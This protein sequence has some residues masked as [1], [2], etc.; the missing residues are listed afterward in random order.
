MKIL[1]SGGGTGGHIYPALSIADELK[2]IVSEIEIVYVGT[3]AGLERNIVPRYGYEMRYIEVA[4]FRR[5]LSF[6]TIR[7]IYLLYKGLKQAKELI[8][9][10][11]PDLVIGTGGYVCGPVVYQAAKAGIPTCIQEQNALP[12][13]TNRILARMVN[14]VLLG[15]EEA[16]KHFKAKGEVVY[17]GNPIREEILCQNRE[18]SY[19]E[20]RLDPQLKTVLVFGGSRG[21]KSINSAMV[22]VELQLSKRNDVQVLHA[23][24]ETNY[25]DHIKALGSKGGVNGNIHIVPYLHN[26][27]SAL[28]VADFVVCR[29]GAIGLA[30]IMA[31]GLPAILIPFPFATGNHQEFNARALESKGAARVILDKDLNGKILLEQIKELLDSPDVL[32]DMHVSALREAKPMAGRDIA[33]TVMACL[34]EGYKKVHFVG[35]G[36]AGM[37][38]IAS[39]LLKRGYKVQGSDLNSGEVV[40]RL[41]GQGAQIKIGHAAENIEGAD[42]LVLSTAIHTDNSEVLAAKEKGIPVFHRSNILSWL[43]NVKDG[44]TVAGAHGK[45]TVTSM[46]AFIADKA[47]I[48][49][50][51]LIGGDV[52]Q[53]GGNAITGDGGYVIAEADE[54][55]GSF[56]KF[57]S[58]IAVVTNIEDDHLDHYG[59]EEN[60]YCAFKEFVANVKEGGRAVLC[61]DN[62][63]VR[64]L[65]NDLEG[66]LPVVTYGLHDGEYRAV[67]IEFKGVGSIYTLLHDGTVIARVELSVPGIHNVQNS[68]GAFAAAASMG[69]SEETIIAGLKEFGGARRRFETKARVDDIWFVDDYAHHPTEIKAVLKAARETGSERIVVCFQ[70]HRYTRTKLLMGEFLHAFD[71][72]DML[73]IT[74]VYAASEESVEGGTSDVLVRNIKAETGKNVIHTPTY[75]DA[76][77]YLKNQ[78]RPGDLV[79]SIGAGRADLVIERLAAERKKL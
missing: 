33:D 49:A 1:I 75:E 11:K 21:A 32:Q 59:T 56:L 8:A 68:V 79:M 6:D 73:V 41:I 54:S 39:V 51:A 57:K 69:I 22:D 25:T 65:V 63:N 43:V 62:V 38:A 19:Q 48:G 37:S 45:T 23:T 15:Y 70:P 17:T 76:Y 3:A 60:I 67:D 9:A 77:N 24:G 78:I 14:K 35:I 30:E 61:V 36:G 5:S 50:T 71:D 58:K 52:A 34:F 10:E 46:L 20:L 28:A 12:G 44:V 16:A 47:G 72:C 26:M 66:A 40:S 2:K 55:D 42:C 53:L 27:P 4:G 13:V 18:R 31:K 74:D 7:S 64:R 29:A